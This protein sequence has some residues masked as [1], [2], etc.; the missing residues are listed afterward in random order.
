MQYSQE[1]LKTMAYAEFGG[2]NRVYYGEFENREYAQPRD[3][4]KN[5]RLQIILSGAIAHLQGRKS[6]NKSPTLNVVI[7]CGLTFVTDKVAGNTVTFRE[8]L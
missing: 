2:A 7:F 5:W 6:Y 1:H 4:A 8:L 3:D